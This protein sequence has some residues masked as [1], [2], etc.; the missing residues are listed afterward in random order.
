MCVCAQL[1]QI[2]QRVAQGGRELRKFA[3]V[4]MN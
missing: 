2:W 4:E 1:Y 3:I